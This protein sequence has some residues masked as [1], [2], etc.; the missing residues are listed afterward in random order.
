MTLNLQ[1]A[2]AIIGILVVA[3]VY[4]ISRWQHRMR[5]PVPRSSRAPGNSA[6]LNLINRDPII[7]DPIT[8]PITR[9][10]HAPGEVDTPDARR[11]DG[12]AG[13]SDGDRDSDSDGTDDFDQAKTVAARDVKLDSQPNPHSEMIQ[14]SQPPP[15]GARDDAART[16]VFGATPRAQAAAASANFGASRIHGFERLSQI[17]YWVKITGARD[18]GRESVLAL[19]QD[20]ATG[21]S[22]TRG[23]YGFQTTRKVWCDVESEAEDSRFTDLVLTIQLADRGGA[24][25]E[26]EM[27]RFSALV[28][29]LSAGT[30]REFV[31]MAPIEN[32]FAQAEKIAAFADQYDSLFAVNI[33]SA[34][35]ENFAGAAID[36]CAVQMG[37]EADDELHYSRYKSIGKS[38]VALYSLADLSDTGRFDYDDMK[39]FTTRGV[40]FF[41]RPA[42]NKSPGAVFA[43]MVDTAKAFASRLKGLVSAPNHDDLTQEEVDATRASIEKVAAE[44]ERQGIAAGSAEAARIF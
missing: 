42:V 2:L 39:K 24:I 9:E 32:A 13:Y 44:M 21:F 8:G 7:H 15:S 31:F 1:T 16:P 37:L 29:R 22:K 30:G 18:V 43:E 12:D 4:L 14:P 34:D 35:G 17:D 27:S 11:A 25:S 40:T 33:H 19:Y 10:A 26:R 41:T 38:K 20:G 23:L 36:R 6:R 5:G 3:A 28:T